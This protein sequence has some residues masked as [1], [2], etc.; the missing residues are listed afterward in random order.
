MPTIVQVENIESKMVLAEPVISSFGQIL[1]PAGTELCES[2]RRILKT[3]NV[4]VVVIKGES[5]NNIEEISE[6]LIKLA[7]N[8]FIERIHWE[9]RNPIEEDLVNIG[10]I[11][12]A[13]S[14]IEDGK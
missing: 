5:A 9:P 8:R 14:I 4:N 1:I 13:Q 3:W 12:L 2:H 6:D 10:I 7:R 11:K